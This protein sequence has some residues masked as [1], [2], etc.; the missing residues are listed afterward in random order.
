M[1]TIL[2][3]HWHQLSTTETL[4]LLDVDPDRGLD[5]FEIGQRP[6]HDSADNAGDQSSR[7]GHAGCDR[8]P[9][10]QRQRDQE[11]DDGCEKILFE[12]RA[13]TMLLFLSIRPG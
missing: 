9:H 2:S 1:N 10:T 13:H 6:D 4:E 12:V 8:N 5:R 3:H 11:H 7:H